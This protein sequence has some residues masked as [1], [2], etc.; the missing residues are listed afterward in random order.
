MNVTVISHSCVL[1]A[2]QRVWAKVAGHEGIQLRMIVPRRWRSS[3]HGVL[4]FE[5]LPELADVARP[6]R[7]YLPGNLHL[8]TY[9]DLGPALT[10]GLPDVLYLDE[11]PHSLAAWQVM[12]LQRLMEFQ[13]VITLKQNILKRYPP[14]RLP[15]GTPTRPPCSVSTPV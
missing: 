3:L 14:S 12:G 5:A 1:P 7:V 9:S 2:N 4:E 8:H 13:L 11:D 10:D 15:Q 6:L